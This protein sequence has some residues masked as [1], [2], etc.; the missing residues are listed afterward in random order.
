MFC[1]PPLDSKVDSLRLLTL[2]PRSPTSEVIEC[3]LET[4]T[5]SSKPSYDALSYTWGTQPATKQIKLN[6]EIFPVREN[7]YD[8]L[9]HL[10]SAESQC[11]WV[12]AVC[13]NQANISERNAQ[14]SLMAFIY[15]RAQKV[16]VWLGRW[17]EP[18]ENGYLSD[19]NWYALSHNP[20]WS[21][22]WIIQELV[23]AH[24]VEFGLGSYTCSWETISSSMNPE[25]MA[26]EGKSTVIQKLREERYTSAQRLEN[27]IET[28]REAQCTEKR[29]KIYGFLGMVND[30]SDMEIDVDY[31]IPFHRLY[32][33]LIRFHQNAR[34]PHDSRLG[35][36]ND[37]PLKLMHFS[38]V[39]QSVLDGSVAE[40]VELVP[41]PTWPETMC[42]AKGFITSEIL[43]L[44]PFRNE[45]ASSIRADKSWKLSF[46][47]TYKKPVDLKKARRSYERFSQEMLCWSLQQMESIRLLYSQ[48]SYGYMRDAGDGSTGTK[49]QNEPHNEVNTSPRLFLGTNATIGCVPD[50][51]QLGDL[52]CTF[53]KSDVA[54]VV[55]KLSE[56]DMYTIIGQARLHIDRNEKQTDEDEENIVY[57]L[58]LLSLGDHVQD[59]T[60]EDGDS[61]MLHPVINM[62]LDLATVQ[63]LTA[64]S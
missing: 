61:S 32:A 5:F 41:D 33:N 35:K 45:I 49:I 62:R 27:L 9:Y 50:G 6:G 47:K 26:L 38:N 37:R 58:S 52:I 16:R 56:A 10:G 31:S 36:E 11:L 48:R 55:R 3:Q 53:F 42:T 24:E 13:I 2:L 43:C 18:I 17:A 30:G 57:N 54:V 64:H 28:F 15:I 59:D 19:S 1:Y 51:T 29:D 44:G 39:V 4:R 40:E 21:R 34:P 8:A 22:L 60:E 14:V 12:D 23:L 20:Y 63:K 25:W 46:S 7:L